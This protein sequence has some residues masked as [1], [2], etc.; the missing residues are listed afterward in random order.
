MRNSLR[1]A[2]F[3]LILLHMCM[4]KSCFGV[5]VWVSRVVVALVD[6]RVDRKMKVVQTLA[7]RREVQTVP[8]L[9]L[10]PVCLTDGISSFSPYPRF[11]RSPSPC[12]FLALVLPS[13]ALALPLSCCRPAPPLHLLCLLSLTLCFLASHS[14]RSLRSCNVEPQLQ[15]VCTSSFSLFSVL[16]MVLAHCETIITRA[17]CTYSHFSFF[18]SICVVRLQ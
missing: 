1:A 11:L 15:Y 10:T 13:L 16:C 7:V 9:V 3:R 2:L 4:A 18:F 17:T 14:P 12:P 8:S 5:L 6:M